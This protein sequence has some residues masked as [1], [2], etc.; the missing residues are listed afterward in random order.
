[1]SC[2]RFLEE[3]SLPGHDETKIDNKIVIESTSITDIRPTPGAVTGCP[4][5]GHEQLDLLEFWH[6]S[7]SSRKP[8]Y[9]H[10]TSS[11]VHS[12]DTT[13]DESLLEPMGLTSAKRARVGQPPFTR[14][15][16]TNLSSDRDNFVKSVDISPDGSQVLL[17][18]EGGFASTLLLDPSFIQ[19]HQYYRSSFG[20]G[21][22]HDLDNS[23]TFSQGVD[24]HI[25]ESIYDTKWY[26]FMN[27]AE[28]ASC[29]FA[30]SSRD[31]PIQ[32]W[33]T[34]GSLR[35]SY[36]GYDRFDELDPA[37]CLSFNSSGDRLYA[38]SDRMIRWF[39]VSRPGKFYTD[40]P[41]CKTRRD[42]MGQKGIISCLGFNPDMSKA[43][44]AGSFANSVCVY[45]EDVRGCVLDI[46]DVG[47][48][49]VTCLKWSPCGNRLWI[50][51][52]HH[53]D[54]ACWDVRKLTKEL[55]RVSRTLESNQRMKFDL[56]PWGCYLFTGSQTGELL[57][58]D[59]NTFQQV[60]QQLLP[61]KA[62]GLS[63]SMTSDPA[64]I[65]DCVNAVSCHPFCSL[66]VSSTGQRHFDNR[67]H[68]EADS[69]SD[70]DCI[71]STRLPRSYSSDSG[72]WCSGVQL[73]SI[74]ADV[75]DMPAAVDAEATGEAR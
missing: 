58:F 38:G 47:V 66:L 52:R 70:N 75:L 15:S 62:P 24:I 26:P 67:D 44:A 7:T 64:S 16:G 49:G 21:Q 23:E 14:L 19:S 74:K 53:P 42:F 10:D 13:A 35:C 37:Q 73:W 6:V 1:M 33:D 51:G 50:G 30:T 48:G 22:H 61:H 39:D 27:A 34:A 40:L 60:N 41:T 63:S 72:S 28:P 8:S 65:R 36:T 32:L 68:D 54:I 31:H 43:Y 56:D 55:G 20:Q 25:G 69:D 71:A 45:A 29:C 5:H 11:S 9:D 59:A 46:R 2:P 3:D 57:T 17:T 12:K 18:T 4:L